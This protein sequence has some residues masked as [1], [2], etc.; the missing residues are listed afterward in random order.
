MQYMLA[1]PTKQTKKAQIVGLSFTFIIAIIVM[2]VTLAVAIYVISN[3]IKTR[4]LFELNK[5]VFDLENEVDAHYYRTKDSRIIFSGSVPKRFELI[6]FASVSRPRNAAVDSDVWNY[7]T[8]FPRK[9]L[10]FFPPQELEKIGAS[11]AF[12]ISL[13]NFDKNPL[14]LKNEGAVRIVLVNEGDY[15]KISNE[16]L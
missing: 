6:C 5:F 16:I 10:F 15:V 1:K 9:N 3:T 2:A 8:K 4:D 7:I 14:C 13:V 12:N 11:N